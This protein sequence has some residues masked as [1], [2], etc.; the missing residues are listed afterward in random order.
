MTKG[1]YCIKITELSEVVSVTP[2]VPTQGAP[3]KVDEK[4]FFDVSLFCEG[5]FFD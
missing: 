4:A 3:K 1:Y 5:F 2:A